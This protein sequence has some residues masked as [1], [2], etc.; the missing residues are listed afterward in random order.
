MVDI[1]ISL[2]RNFGIFGEPRRELRPALEGLHRSVATVDTATR[3][4]FQFL[5]VGTICDDEVVIIADADG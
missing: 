5:P 1:T 4:I 3:R 2:L